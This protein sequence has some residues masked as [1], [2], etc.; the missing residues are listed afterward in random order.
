MAKK[1][2]SDVA[3]ETTEEK[4]EKTSKKE[5]T[6]PVAE[7]A[8]QKKEKRAPQL[9][10]PNGDKVSHMH[11]F[12]SNKSDDWFVAGKINDVPLKPQ[13]VSN[14]DMEGFIAKTTTAE[15]LMWKYYP[16]K[17]MVKVGEEQY[18]NLGAV[19]T[20]DGMQ[21][22]HKFNVYKENDP[23][24]VDYGKYRFY[25]QVGDKRM[26]ESA[27]K[28]DL[29]MY[30][31]RV[32]SP[33]DIVTQKFGERLHMADHYKMFTLP[34]GSNIQDKDIKLRKNQESN[35]Y[36]ISVNLGD[37][38]HTPSKEVSF[39]DRQSFFSHKT[40]TKEQL[41]SKYLFSEIVATMSQTPKQAQAKQ[42]SMAM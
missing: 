40:A 30:F 8:E 29:D 19:Q 6:A 20:P 39:D 38:G 36:E 32:M 24:N 7:S 35:R 1:K 12:K 26:S 27:S 17:M 31:D 10:T 37:K 18:K 9:I 22:I 14:Q 5:S 15:Q 4:K 28:R 34:E 11:V 13:K 21:Q 25:A 33:K 3:P 16:T 41:A 2:A 23:K 42:M